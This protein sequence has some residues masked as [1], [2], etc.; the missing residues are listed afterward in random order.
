MTPWLL[1]KAFSAA[2]IPLV[3]V[4]CGSGV[5]SGI[6]GKQMTPWLLNK[7]FSAKITTIIYTCKRVFCV[8]V[9]TYVPIFQG[10][11]ARDGRKL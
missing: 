2:W 4:F 1:N 8:T 9:N 5:V 6:R 7:T 10:L 11:D 3:S